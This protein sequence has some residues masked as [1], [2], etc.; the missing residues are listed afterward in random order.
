MISKI[1]NHKYLLC[2]S[3]LA[4]TAIQIPIAK[5][6]LPLISF[7]LKQQAES[8]QKINFYPDKI[9]LIRH[10]QSEA[11][12]TPK[13]YRTVPD[14][15]VHLSPNGKQQAL[16]ASHLLKK[17][18]GEGPIK[19]YI[20]PY[21]RT[22]E[23]FEG[24][25]T[26]LKTNKQTII[27][28]PRIREQ[29]LGN[30]HDF[31]PEIMKERKVVSDYYYRFRDGESG[32]DVYNRALLFIDRMFRDF[33][34]LNKK[35]HNTVVIVCHRWFM[36]AFITAFFNLNANDFNEIKDAQNCGL[37]IIEKNAKGK[38]KLK[39]KLPRIKL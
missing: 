12:I 32:A 39:T 35:E 11:N 26:Q 5:R 19:F 30:F 31:Y 22:I 16:T 10:G 24:I 28:D 37:W 15:L 7:K 13:I 2:S 21:I 1:L 29:E 14:A 9:I 4:T 23:T 33:K 36:R 38:Y 3:L 18:V 20:S 6:L 27:Y 34:K 8:Y 17:E 25:R